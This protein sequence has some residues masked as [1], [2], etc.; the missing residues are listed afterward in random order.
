M[1]LFKHL[2]SFLINIFLDLLSAVS[3]TI[4]SVGGWVPHVFQIVGTLDS[5]INMIRQIPSFFPCHV[6]EEFQL[7]FAVK[8]VARI[9][10]EC[11]SIVFA[12][13]HLITQV[14]AQEHNQ[15]P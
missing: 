7:V 10:A 2:H 8:G 11:C 5:A 4:D 9:Q 13:G 15:H 3:K 6:A 12:L 14:D 1:T